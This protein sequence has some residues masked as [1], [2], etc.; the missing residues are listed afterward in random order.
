MNRTFISLYQQPVK[1]VLLYILLSSL[2]ILF[3]D[4]IVEQLFLSPEFITRV[5]TLK[6]WVLVAGSGLFLYWIIHK[7]NRELERNRDHYKTMLNNAKVG[8]ARMENLEI[9]SSNPAFRQ[10]L[11]DGEEKSENSTF[12]DLLDEFDSH[13]FRE[14]LQNL[15]LK[16]SVQHE[17]QLRISENR[18]KWVQFIVTRYQEEHKE[19][20]QVILQ[21]I[22]DRKTYQA[23]TDL[24]LKVMLTLEP[25]DNFNDALEGILNNLCIELNWE[26]GIAYTPDKDG[27]FSKQVSWYRLDPLLDEFDFR[28]EKQ[29]LNNNEGL[30]GKSFKEK[31]A[32][33]I[34][35]AETNDSL[36][37]RQFVI[38]ADLRS[39]VA[40]PVVVNN[41]VI[42]ILE[43][44]NR[45]VVARDSDLLRLLTAI[46]H[47]IG[48]KLE[49]RKQQ[50]ERQKL[51]E[52]LNFALTSAEMATWDIE[53][54]TG[55]I[56]SSQN[57]FKLFGLK[58]LP[59]EWNVQKLIETIIPE[60]QARVEKSLTNAVEETRGFNTEFRIEKEGDIRWLWSRGDLK[61]DDFGEPVRLS[62][63]VTDVT[64]RK[65]FQ[66][67]TE[68]LLEIILSIDH[69]RDIQVSFD[70][71]LRTICRK[72]LWQY[73][74]IWQIN[75][76]TGK[77]E[78]TNRWYNDESELLKSFSHQSRD[79]TFEN[80]V[81]MPGIGFED[82]SVIWISDISS[83][84]RFKRRKEALDAG[85][86]SVVSIPV[87]IKGV[88]NIRILLFSN[89]P[90][91][92]DQDT[93][94][95]LKAISN[96][97]GVQ[98]ARKITLERLERTEES[99]K[100]ALF[101]SQMAAWDV[102]LDSG[103]ILLSDN[104]Q[105]VINISIG[106]T[107][108]L[109][110][111]F[112]QIIGKDREKLQSH[113]LDA[114]RNKGEIDIEIQVRNDNDQL[115]WLW[116]HGHFS[117]S[118]SSGGRISGIV[119]DITERIE[120]EYEL[121]RERELLELLYEH[122]P[123]MITVYRPDFSN[124]RINN[125]FENV[126]GWRNED[127]EGIN[128]FDEVFPEKELQYK[129]MEFMQAPDSGWMDMPMRIR[130][131][132]IIQSTW[133][134][135]RLS[136]D[137]QIGIGLDITGRKKMEDQLKE[138]KLYLSESQRIANLGTYR[139]NLDTGEAEATDILKAI[140]GFEPDHDLHISDWDKTLHPE[141]RDELKDY[142]EEVL[143]ER[144]RFEKEYKIIR[145]NDGEEIWLYEN[146]E[147]E[148]DESG[149]PVYMIG[150]V[151]DITRRKEYE[152][153]IKRSE[154]IASESRELLR[155]IFE[156]LEEAVII[157]N[158]ITRKI[159]D[160]NQGAERIFGYRRDEMMGR[161]TEFLHVNMTKYNEFHERSIKKLEESGLFTT[162]F[163][164]R[165]KSGETFI[166]DHTVTVVEDDSGKID[167]I[168]SVIRD[169]TERKIHQENIRKHR[170]R[171][172]EAE[173]VARMGHWEFNLDTR[174]LYWSDMVFKI[175]GLDK[176][177][178][179]LSVEQ[180]IKHVHPDDR[181]KIKTSEERLL[182]DG[183]LEHT[184]RFIKPDGNILYIQERGQYIVNDDGKF[185]TG[186]V[187][188]ITDLKKTEEKLETERQRFELAIGAVSDVIWDYDALAGTLWWN[189]GIETVFGYN[190]DEISKEY[191]FWENHIYEED[192]EETVKS[193]RQ[194]ESSNALE[195]LAF[196]RFLDAEGN[197]REVE[198][199]ARI[200]R[201]D[202]GNLIRIIG[203]MLD[204][205]ELKMYR[206]E[207]LQERTRFEIIAQSTNDIIYDLNLENNEIWAND[208]LSTI[209]G[210]N[211]VKDSEPLK[212]W[213]EHIHPD[214]KESVLKSHQKFL[215]AGGDRWEREYRFMGKNNKVIYIHENS[216][217][218]RGENGTA[219]RLLGAM[220]DVSSERETER[221]LR[222]SEEQ[223]RRLF[224][225]NPYPMLIYNPTS[226]KIIQ[227]NQATQ[228]T[229]GY[230]VDEF[231]KM[232]IYEFHPAKDRKEIK[233]MLS[234]GR[235]G[236]SY[237]SDIVH[238]TKTG[239]NIAVNIT[240]LDI[241]Y[242]GDNQRLVVINNITEQKKA[243]ERVIGSVI[244]GSEN[245]RRRIAKELHDGLGQYLTAASLN[246]DSVYD[247]LKVLPENK[248]KQYEKGL[249][250]L[251]DAIIESRRISQN[252]LPKAIEDFG[253][254]LAVQSLVDD[255]SGGSNI[256]ITYSDNLDGIG[257]GENVELNIY[258]IIQEGINNA[259]RHS[260]CKWLDIQLILDENQLIC[261]IE[262]NGT[263]F[264]LNTD[265]SYGLG[266]TN[267]KN[268]VNALSGEIEISSRT[269]KGTLITV[270]VPVN[271]V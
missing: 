99:L 34:E 128:I 231:K 262:D 218:I 178:F 104:Y 89:Y 123:V 207:L 160:C 192:R 208:E 37:Y 172:L 174:E 120:T 54:E 8:I 143:T 252:L 82:D 193:M 58:Y 210:Y 94:S 125:E 126:T 203:A 260:G 106:Q 179:E 66:V 248:I 90:Q 251:R 42:A 188:D 271:V 30:I 159:I 134:N 27:V 121:R 91:S 209:M 84:N 194:A 129:I 22:N 149:N 86:K 202:E 155:K 183:K 49:K 23:Y 258:R 40:I 137:T 214:D 75:N 53:L 95:F 145:F 267:I 80:G 9:V 217:A 204:V 241:R 105:D 146:A 43:L 259:V 72:D 213:Q 68:L 195:W 190:R 38:D 2:W 244:E 199:T 85:L 238:Q 102:D 162:E 187:L 98:I 148:L 197:I 254:G 111:N 184:Y 119:R 97:I 256:E 224:E 57:H 228:K 240:A 164:L 46:G 136:D 67:Y 36:E 21:D 45:E 41:E 212:W 39:I 77:I 163:E 232:T 264:Q 14:S 5:Q 157:L 44:Y 227:V 249:N 166:S 11:N 266:I 236:L 216:F 173:E 6:G 110:F 185:L 191:K 211:P 263:G 220:I 71:I 132:E 140:F 65:K 255:I 69:L 242:K 4:R 88:D 116:V 31:K 35:D 223:Y 107:T 151:Q 10:I 127:L 138:Q 237:Y 168:V 131:G 239:E 92:E 55:K 28:L 26:Y 7:S 257:L 133:T 60:D 230:S 152:L 226:E 96:N 246:F 189:E 268:R 135:V 16:V 219:T 3:T 261:T 215:E 265:D 250:L 12:L 100:Y 253:L 87:D 118:E 78:C 270:I 33:W 196:Y 221:I 171:L 201:D 29:R 147:L 229:Y 62:G 198:D 24:L 181:E 103:R 109:D 122:I 50:D 73:A 47:D 25:S 139:L 108:N 269:G 233:K 59:A 144:K 169:I 186:T 74:E 175:F 117:E 247:E 15:S 52:S 141:Y 153:E 51:E 114:I 167:R 177:S 70:Q 20:Y 56:L 124:F 19:Y 150:S 158:P 83:D 182:K 161:S 205:T 64:Q 222:E 245:E 13:T 18:R 115:R 61:F 130:S 142:F 170:D 81:G 225:Q 206:R 243:E 165:K 79:I 113:I 101:S 112:P 234:G 180:F 154:A 235:N 176:S 17:F 1:M 48:I 156:S 76:E 93:I 63:V 200:I 32:A